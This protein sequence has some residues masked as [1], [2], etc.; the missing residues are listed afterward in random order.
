MCGVCLCVVYYMQ[1]VSVCS[2]LC[3]VY[4]CACLCVVYYVSACR[5]VCVMCV[6]V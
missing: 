4:V 2:V 3:V 1:C 5:V 6:G